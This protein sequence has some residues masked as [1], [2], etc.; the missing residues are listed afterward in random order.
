MA[1]LVAELRWL[2]CRLLSALLFPFAFLISCLEVVPVE[3]MSAMVDKA[4]I[5]IALL[6]ALALGLA[7]VYGLK[8]M[9]A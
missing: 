9:F 1:L 8:I 4:V 5:A 2:Y 6:S 7:S 3:T